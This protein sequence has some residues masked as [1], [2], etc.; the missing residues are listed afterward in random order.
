MLPPEG[1]IYVLF[2]ELFVFRRVG[3]Q[4]RTRL[5]GLWYGN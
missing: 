1:F 2:Q 5:F 4:I 3:H